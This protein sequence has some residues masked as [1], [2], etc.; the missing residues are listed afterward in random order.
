MYD[1]V[2]SCGGDA[3]K[4]GQVLGP[5]QHDPRDEYISGMFH[6][7]GVDTTL[8]RILG[9]EHAPVREVQAGSQ[10]IPVAKSLGTCFGCSQTFTPNASVVEALD[11]LY[12][13]ACFKC[14]GPCQKSLV[15]PQDSKCTFQT[16]E[17]RPYCM[18]CVPKPVPPSSTQSKSPLSQSEHSLLQSNVSKGKEQCLF[19]GGGF[20]ATDLG[21]QLSSHGVCHPNCLKCTQCS[22][23]MP[24]L[25][26]QMHHGK[27]YHPSCYKKTFGLCCCVCQKGIDGKYL[28]DQGKYYHPTC[29]KCAMCNTTL[30][31]TYANHPVTGVMCCIPCAKKVNT[32][33]AA[34]TIATQAARG[35]TI[36]PMTGLKKY[37]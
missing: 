12:H 32:P 30:A 13:P 11:H 34:A 25:E 22:E 37:R 36:D 1:L 16:W 15:S 27:P 6:S 5:K 8:T 33:D 23:I 4:S 2:P 24:P 29:L 18:Q 7:H 3:V 28:M 31:S 10:E 19:C 35:F 21:I 9:D 26:I 20:Q 17:Q 14:A